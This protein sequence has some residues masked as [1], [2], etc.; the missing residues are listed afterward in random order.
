MWQVTHKRRAGDM[1]TLSCGLS[2]LVVPHRTP[3]HIRVDFTGERRMETATT[4][5]FKLKPILGTYWAR[6]RWLLAQ[7]VLYNNRCANGCIR[8]LV[9]KGCI[10]ILQMWTVEFVIDEEQTGLW[11]VTNIKVIKHKMCV[12]IFSTTLSEA[13]LILRSGRDITKNV[14]WSLHEVSVIFVRF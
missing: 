4:V 2:M 5:L 14:H 11:K 8:L 10:V 9:R 3:D 13:V 6:V 12:F 1:A 7:P